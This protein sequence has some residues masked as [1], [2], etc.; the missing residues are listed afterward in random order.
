MQHTQQH[1]VNWFELPV[2]DID[3][4]QSFYETILARTLRREQSPAARPDASAPTLAIF[5]YDEAGVGGCLVAGADTPRPTTDGAVVYLNASPSLDAALE[6]VTAAGGRI[7]V[8]RTELPG[9]MG[10][11]AHIADTEGNRVGLHALA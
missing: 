11:F 8:P 3:R 7:L 10:A 9:D 5:P 2:R 4:A 6:R 1:A